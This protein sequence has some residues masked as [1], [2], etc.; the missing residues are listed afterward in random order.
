MRPL[1]NYL[2][3][4]C[5]KIGLVKTA[6]WLQRAVGEMRNSVRCF[7]RPGSTGRH[8]LIVMSSGMRDA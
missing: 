5:G 4:A 1:P 7:R 8:R 2:L 6:R 3:E